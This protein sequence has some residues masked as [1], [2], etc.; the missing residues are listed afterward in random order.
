M[1]K[2]AVV[3]FSLVF[4]CA[5]AFAQSMKEVQVSSAE[6]AQHALKHADPLYPPIAKAAHVQGT[7]R[8]RLHVDETGKVK[9]VDVIVGPPMLN[10]AAVDAARQ[11]TYT[12]FQVDGKPASVGVEDSIP[13]SLGIPAATEKRDEAIGQ[14]FFPL[15][16]QCRS[17]MSSHN[18]PLSVK[19][20]AETAATADRFPHP[21][22]RAN[23][24]R[25]AHEDYGQALM[26]SHDPQ[27]ALNQFHEA[28]AIANK[29][30]T[31]K[32][33]EYASAYY[34][35]ALAEHVLQMTPEADRDYMIAETSY[36]A[37]II[38]LPEMTKIYDPSLA[39]TLAYHSLLA[40]QTGHADEAQAMQT[41]ALKLDPH[42][43]DGMGIS[44][45]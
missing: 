44:K 38:Q 36:R 1:N 27:H 12:P 35:Q 33:E 43:L 19:L 37:A 25:G 32:D 22:S 26:F 9:K 41:E 18:W 20:C 4:L 5:V 14:A 23:E 34:F 39:R 40:N 42:S 2:Q 17:A 6:A 28:V 45:Q 30:L 13:F 16:N 3:K 11:W 10:S 7:V 29:S 8:L 15:E 31:P 21:A 24:R